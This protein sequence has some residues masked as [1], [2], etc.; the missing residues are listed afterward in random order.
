MHDFSKEHGIF[1][2]RIGGLPVHVHMLCDI[3]AKIAVSEF[4]KLI[5][6]ETSKFMR[7]NPHFP[8]WEG[9]SEGYGGFTVDASL[10]GPVKFT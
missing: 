3:S 8:K 10:R 4:V 5:K 1:I 2:R 9:W 7:V 6:T